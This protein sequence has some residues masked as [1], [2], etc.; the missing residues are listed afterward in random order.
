MTTGNN[1]NN[2]N[3]I[4]RK[5]KNKSRSL[6]YLDIIENLGFSGFNLIVTYVKEKLNI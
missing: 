1:N 6:F 4:Q 2:N 5:N 3:K